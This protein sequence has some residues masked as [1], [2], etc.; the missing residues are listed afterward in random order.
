MP[1]LTR[2]LMALA[3]ALPT[4]ALLAL[5]TLAA[6]TFPEAETIAA[7]ERMKASLRAKPDVAIVRPPDPDA[8]KYPY[9]DRVVATLTHHCASAV[10]RLPRAVAT[11]I[12]RCT[13]TGLQNRYPMAEFKRIGQAMAAG[14]PMPMPMETIVAG[15]TQQALRR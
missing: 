11:Q 3:L 13:V 12:C 6:S 15:C 9:P 2:P 1:N 10:Q 5:P 14:A 8:V 4:L 7:I